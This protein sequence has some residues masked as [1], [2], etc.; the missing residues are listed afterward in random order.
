[1]KFAIIPSALLLFGLSVSCRLEKD[2]FLPGIG[3]ECTGECSPGLVCVDSLCRQVCDEPGG[4]DDKLGCVEGACMECG[5]VEDCRFGEDCLEGECL[6][7]LKTN[8]E[9]CM[10]PAECLSG[11]CSGGI[12]CESECKEGCMNCNGEVPGVCRR[13]ESPEC[14]IRYP[15]DA[16]SLQ[17]AIS[18]VRDGGVITVA[19]DSFGG[20]V[21]E[22]DK[23]LV[24]EG[25]GQ[26]PPE[27][28]NSEGETGILILD[29]GSVIIRNLQIKGGDFGVRILAPVPVVLERV[30][31]IASGVGVEVDHNGVW[32]P[33]ARTRLLHTDLFFNK[34]AGMIVR[35][36]PVT[37][38]GARLHGNGRALHVQH[39]LGFEMVDSIVSQSFGDFG[40]TFLSTSNVF[41]SGSLFWEN[42]GLG[43]LVFKDVTDSEIADSVFNA[44]GTAGIMLLESE[45]IDIL[46]VRLSEHVNIFY[47]AVEFNTPGESVFSEILI[48]E[49][50]LTLPENTESPGDADY[51]F[52][53]DYYLGNGISINN[54][55]TVLLLNVKTW[56]NEGAGVLIRDSS[57]IAVWSG[58]I[59]LND[60]GGITSDSTEDLW[61]LCV[62]LF[63]NRGTGVHVV[64]GTSIVEHSE[65]L[66]TFKD[67]EGSYGV[68]ITIQDGN[69]LLQY[70]D[71]Y[72]NALF[73]IFLCGSAHAEIYG[74]RIHGSLLAIA[75]NQGTF[76]EIGEC[77]EVSCTM[78]NECIQWTTIGE[79]S[80]APPPSMPSRPV[81]M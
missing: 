80:P 64:G 39:A 74:N 6:M 71:I 23:N 1:M 45:N 81:E 31:S 70:N 24:I 43:S 69:H 63:G 77:N 75:R 62:G 10:D 73:G 28:V 5:R 2:R 9:E 21:I 14:N 12:C 7:V 16:E 4:C 15:G 66:N 72:N 47:N 30:H 8:G 49:G 32:E 27:I 68:G 58:E 59:S 57:D 18:L 11:F 3:G 46:S 48:P 41:I 54:C 55:T 40:A 65:Q 26:T 35:S 51:D 67:L 56:R 36:A 78:G 17:D 25:D 79:I 76:S 44:N 22:T 29:A 34:T 52:G 60:L 13:D 33:E 61:L 38:K 53:D 50:F 37:V 19:Q 20:I 42:N